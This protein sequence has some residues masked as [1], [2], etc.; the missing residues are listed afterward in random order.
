MSG[1][2]LWFLGSAFSALVSA[3]FWVLAMRDGDRPLAWATT[4][5]VV[6]FSGAAA[7]FLWE[8]L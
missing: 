4:I 1:P 3:V 5:A 8:L 6:V 2:I 7:R